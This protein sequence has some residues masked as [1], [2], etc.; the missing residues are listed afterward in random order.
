[1]RI[2]VSVGGPDALVPSPG[3]P[4]Y[5]VHVAVGLLSDGGRAFG[6]ETLRNTEH[7]RGIL[8]LLNDLLE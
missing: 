6:R 1:M 4:G 2:P 5:Y 7:F 3:V 8:S